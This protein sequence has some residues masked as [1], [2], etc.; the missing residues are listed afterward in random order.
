MSKTMNKDIPSEQQML[1]ILRNF[2]RLQ[3]EN[4]KLRN[5]LLRSTDITEKSTLLERIDK[6]EKREEERETYLERLRKRIKRL[7]EKVEN[8]QREIYRIRY[9]QA[10]KQDIEC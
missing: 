5:L 8:K 6:L 3:E 10:N 2:Q 7:E 4:Q 1:Y 9:E